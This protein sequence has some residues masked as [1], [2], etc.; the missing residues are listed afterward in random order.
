MHT[1]EISQS[2]NLEI[3]I[4]CCI[5]ICHRIISLENTR[6]P[7]D[8]YVAFLLVGELGSSPDFARKI[9]PMAGFRNI[10][11][12]EYLVLDWDEVYRHLQQL[13]ELEQFADKIRHWLHK[14]NE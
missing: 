6:K 13:S 5:D 2:V 3:A 14:K 9:A 12:H 1:C 7:A 8:Y 4:Q 11:I 10:L